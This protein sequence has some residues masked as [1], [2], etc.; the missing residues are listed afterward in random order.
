M[1][2][3]HGGIFTH[4]TGNEMVFNGDILAKSEKVVVVIVTH[5]LGLTGFLDLR[6]LEAGGVAGSAN[7]GMLDIVEALR[8]V[9]DNIA[10]F[11]GDPDRV[12]IFG[13]SGGS[14]KVSTLSAM[15]AAR[16]LFHRA[17]MQ[18]GP[19]RR[20]ATPDLA[21]RVRD[22]TL[23]ALGT[24][25]LDE[26]RSIPLE[27]LMTAQ[28]RVMDEV[29]PI[30]GG[31]VESLPGFG[32]ALD[33][34]DIPE[35]PF[36]E[37]P[38][39]VFDD[40]PLMIGW[41]AHEAAFMMAE[42][43]RFTA[44]MTDEQ[45]VGELEALAPG[46]GSARFAAAAAAA[47]ADPPHLVLARVVEEMTGFRGGSVRIADMVAGRGPGVWA[48]QFEQ[49][50][51]V[52]GGLLGACHSL[53]LAYVFGTVERIPLTGSDPRRMDVSRQMMHAWASFAR[54]GVPAVPGRWAPWT[55][56]SRTPHVFSGSPAV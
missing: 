42:F 12:T 37:A 30:V 49:T 40:I 9:R 24:R 56:D 55:T 18:S 29:S 43:P 21:A 23:R 4:G 27:D 46:E 17:I 3:L 53:D 14:A 26:L 32:P 16:G 25:D 1:V 19:L 50:T 41:T 10:S 44:S 20:L 48:Y 39:S 34:V 38:S 8:W 47:P 2:W 13:Q 52:L 31:S 45:A 33:D 35:H 28:R 15:P 22:L 5:R 51:D 36:D 54:D 11:G 7:A 6:A